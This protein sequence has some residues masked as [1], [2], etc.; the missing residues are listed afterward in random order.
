MVLT[1]AV[2]FSIKKMDLVLGL[3]LK[4]SFRNIHLWHGHAD[5]VGGKVT[6]TIVAVESSDTADT[7]GLVAVCKLETIPCLDV[8][9]AMR[10]DAMSMDKI[11]LFC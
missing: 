2:P 10:V 3:K 7:I 5:K 11:P 9:A 4:T 1:T 6:A 8:I